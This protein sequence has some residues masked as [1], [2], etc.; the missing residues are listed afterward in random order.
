MEIGA[1]K[2]DYSAA[3]NKRVLCTVSPGQVLS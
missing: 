1:M 2:V 3:E